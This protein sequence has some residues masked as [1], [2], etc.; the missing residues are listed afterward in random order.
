MRTSPEEWKLWN[1]E[2]RLENIHLQRWHQTIDDKQGWK[3]AK[4]ENI[5]IGQSIYCLIDTLTLL[6]SI[7]INKQYA[8][9]FE[10]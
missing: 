5:E 10:E 4:K 7:S 8:E 9:G 2:D 6:T 3:Q 1:G